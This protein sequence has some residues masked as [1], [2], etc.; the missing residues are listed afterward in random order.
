MHSKAQADI[1]DLMID[2][3]SYGKKTIVLET[4]SENLL[5]RLRRR[6]AEGEIINSENV[7]IYYVEQRDVISRVHKM[8]LNQLGDIENI[9]DDFKKYF[10]DDYKIT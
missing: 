1:A 9:P 3:I 5:L 6:V 8:K 7:A 4:H 2:A 10:Q